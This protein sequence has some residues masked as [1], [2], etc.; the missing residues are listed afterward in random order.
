MS[1]EEQP[2]LD[3][4]LEQLE[5]EINRLADGTGPVDDLVTAHEAAQRLID[6]AQVELRRLL[7]E[8]SPVLEAK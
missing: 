2:S 8:V 1:G 7:A 4:V 3:D 6:Q 5:K